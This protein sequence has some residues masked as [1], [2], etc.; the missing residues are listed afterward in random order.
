MQICEQRLQFIYG[1]KQTAHILYHS[2]KVD[3]KI[4]CFTI[5]IQKLSYW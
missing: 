4:I 2:A 1:T 5:F 3:Q